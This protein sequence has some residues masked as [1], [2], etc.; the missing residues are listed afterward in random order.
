ML[1]LRMSGPMEPVEVDVAQIKGVT[2]KASRVTPLVGFAAH[3]GRGFR[4]LATDAVLGKT[5][6]FPR[7]VGDLDATWLSQIIG[8]AV[9]SVEVLDGSAGT[10]SRSRLALTGDDV[11]ETVF[12]KMSAETAA[13][14][15]LGEL[16]KLGENE[17][18]F[19]RE[20]SSELSGVPKA[21]G[22]SWDSLTG[23]FVIVLEDLPRDSVEFFDTLHPMSIDQA[24]QLVETLAHVHGTF[25]NR[26]P[27]GRGKGELGW[28]TATSDERSLPISRPLMRMSARRLADR[29]SIPIED[30]RFVIENYPAAVR[31]IDDGH[32]TVL[33]GDS[34]PG[35]IYFRNG[36]AGLLDW[37]VVKRG[38]PT[39]DIAYSLITGM[40]TDDRRANQR[41]LLDVYRSALA[42]GGGPD[43]DRDD[44]W[45]RYRQAAVQPFLASLTTAG[46]GGMQSEEIAFEGLRRAVEA[47]ADLDTVALLQNS[48]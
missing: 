2:E 42:A 14:R 48:L 29:T 13:T 21:Y 38:H 44:L 10:S 31:H 12:V 22:S 45:D 27:A 25:W 19:Y 24:G 7:A 32:H 37:Q 47:F 20:L 8:R 5:R 18:R 43:L 1:I 41:D 35:N 17:A 33:H 23:R 6:A 4:R 9:T 26:L 30:G 11:P 34:H 39:R 36:K 3:L 28:L 16:A 46:L 40:T 15:M